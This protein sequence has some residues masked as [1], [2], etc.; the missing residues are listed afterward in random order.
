MVYDALT[1]IDK[2]QIS[3][4]F[5]NKTKLQT[6]TIINIINDKLQPLWTRRKFLFQKN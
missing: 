3:E 4:E 2:S 1:K 5:L 6:K